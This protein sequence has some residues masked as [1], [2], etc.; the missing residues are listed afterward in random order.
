MKKLQLHLLA[1]MVREIPKEEFKNDLTG[2]SLKD[3][4]FYVTFKQGDGEVNLVKLREGCL[5]QC[6]DDMAP[7]IEEW[8]QHQKDEGNATDDSVVFT[9]EN[10]DAVLHIIFVEEE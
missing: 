2:E 3:D 1:T 8:I 7:Q 6:P 9:C 10:S 4:L 5:E